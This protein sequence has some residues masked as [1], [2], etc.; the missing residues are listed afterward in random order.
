MKQEIKV[1]YCTVL[2]AFSWMSLLSYFPLRTGLL[3]PLCRLT[4]KKTSFFQEEEKELIL[5]IPGCG[6]SQLCDITWR[7]LF[8]CHFTCF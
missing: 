4:Q 8:F 2:N 7:I 3:L 1:T 5:T 6:L